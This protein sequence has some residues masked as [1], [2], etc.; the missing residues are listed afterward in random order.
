MQVT[1][2]NTGVASDHLATVEAN[3]LSHVL[4]NV[5]WFSEAV[6]RFHFV[7]SSFGFVNCLGELVGNRGQYMLDHVS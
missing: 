6:F 5:L 7:K 1:A 4:K 2:A 3:R